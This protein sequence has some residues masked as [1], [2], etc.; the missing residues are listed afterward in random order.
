MKKHKSKV[1]SLLCILCIPWLSSSCALFKGGDKGGG[2]GSVRDAHGRPIPDD[3]KWKLLGDAHH[4]RRASFERAGLDPD[5][6][7]RYSPTIELLGMDR[8]NSQGPIAR[9]VHGTNNIRP[10]QT[11]GYTVQL[12]DDNHSFEQ[13]VLS[14][15][16][17]GHTLVQGELRYPHGAHNYSFG[18]DESPGHPK[19]LIRPDGKRVDMGYVIAG[20]W[21]SRAWRWMK[22]TLNPLNWGHDGELYESLEYVPAETETE[23]QE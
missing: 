12:A 11:K 22:Q 17:G 2:P 6:A 16:D 5:L 21:P 18:P 23:P 1:L 15:E 19:Y 8:K 13:W 20:R 3:V 7:D 9:N 4:L 14:H 10:G